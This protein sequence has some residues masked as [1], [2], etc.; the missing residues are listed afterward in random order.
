M[1]GR[2][3][4]MVQASHETAATGQLDHILK[5]LVSIHVGL[6]SGTPGDKEIER[7]TIDRLEALMQDVQ[8]MIEAQQSATRT[9][10]NAAY[11]GD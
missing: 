1:K 8:G 2:T 11:R 5:Q 6:A 10:E 4:T 3:P 7:R 9:E